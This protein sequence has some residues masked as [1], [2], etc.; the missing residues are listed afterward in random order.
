[1]KYRFQTKFGN[2]TVHTKYGD[3]RFSGGFYETIDEG[4]A[5]SLRNCKSCVEV[6]VAEN[7]AAAP[8]VKTAAAPAPVAT[9]APAPVPVPASAPKKRGPAPKPKDTEK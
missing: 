2:L 7:T 3:C 9:P 1:M 8:A 4:R 6:K 5:R